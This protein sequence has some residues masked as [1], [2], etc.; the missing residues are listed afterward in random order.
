MDMISFTQFVVAVPSGGYITETTAKPPAGK[1]QPGQTLPDNLLGA[2]AL[3]AWYY[4]TAGQTQDGSGRGSEKY[5]QGEETRLR[6]GGFLCSRTWQKSDSHKD[7]ESSIIYW[8]HATFLTH[9]SIRYR[10]LMV[11]PKKNSFTV[12]IYPWKCLKS[13]IKDRTWFCV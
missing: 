4:K 3:C 6:G 2:E 11:L 7:R 1:T 8:V 12:Y 5:E 9:F 10:I 13:S